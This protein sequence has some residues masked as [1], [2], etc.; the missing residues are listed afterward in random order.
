MLL[1]AIFV[2]GDWSVSQE[3]IQTA[4]S[5][6]A[7]Y[8]QVKRCVIIPACMGVAWNTLVGG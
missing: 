5:M 7:S 4:R 8:G 2:L 1:L 6:G 3:Q